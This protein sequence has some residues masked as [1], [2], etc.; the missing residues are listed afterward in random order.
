MQEERKIDFADLRSIININNAHSFQL[1]IDDIYQELTSHKKNTKGISK[2]TFIDFTHLPITIAEKLFQSLVHQNESHLDYNH[3][4]KFLKDLYI[5]EFKESARVI[6]NIY[7]F[8]KD[9]EININDVNHILKLLPI[10]EDNNINTMNHYIYQLESLNQ[11]VE[12]LNNFFG[13]T[14]SLNFESFLCNLETKNGDIF[15]QLICYLYITLPVTKES[16]WIYN[17]IYKKRCSDL[18]SNDDSSSSLISISSNIELNSTNLSICQNNKLSPLTDF[19]AINN[20]KSNNLR[21]SLKR[22]KSEMQLYKRTATPNMRLN[23]EFMFTKKKKSFNFD[24]S[25]ATKMYYI[26]RKPSELDES[27]DF[28]GPLSSREKT[29]NGMEVVNT[30]FVRKVSN[31]N[32]NKTVLQPTKS[33]ELSNLLK[34]S[35]EREK[36]GSIKKVISERDRNQRMNTERMNTISYKDKLSL[37]IRIINPLEIDSN[38]AED[39]DNYIKVNIDP[40]NHIKYEHKFDYSKTVIEEDNE[41]DEKTF[42]KTSI[43][44]ANLLKKNISNKSECLLTRNFSNEANSQMALFN[45]L[46]DLPSIASTFKDNFNKEEL[47]KLDNKFK[48]G[49]ESI[50]KFA[51]NEYKS[52]DLSLN[53][54]KFEETRKLVPKISPIKIFKNESESDYICTS[55]NNSKSSKIKHLNSNEIKNKNYNVDYYNISNIYS[56]GN[57]YRN[58]VKKPNTP[59]VYSKAYDADNNNSNNSNKKSLEDLN[60]NLIKNYEDKLLNQTKEEEKAFESKLIRKQGELLKLNNEAMSFKSFYVKLLHQNLYYYKEADEPEESYHKM[61]YING[62]FVKK[63]EPKNLKNRLYYCFSITF[64]NNNKTKKYYHKDEKEIKSWMEAINQA[65]NFKD[66]FMDYRLGDLLGKG[67]YGIVKIG[68]HKKT[69]KKMALKIINKIEIPTYDTMKTEIE[70][71]KLSKHPNIVQYIDYYENSEFIFIVMEYL[72]DGTLEEYLN[73]T[74]GKLTEQKAAK[75]I[76][77]IVSGLYYLKQFGIIHRDL[78][79]N[80]ILINFIDKDKTKRIVDREISVKIADFGFSKILGPKEMANEICGTIT[81]IAPEILRNMYYDYKVD[82]WSLGIIMYNIISRGDLPF[83][84]K[85]HDFNEMKKITLTKE[86][87]FDEK[88]NDK[89]NEVKEL[90]KKCLIKE[91]EKR[92]SIEEVMKDPWFRIIEKQS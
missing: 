83:Y 58:Q 27:V 46:S 42:S 61:H 82:V 20:T 35:P 92:I 34:K 12:H 63:Q 49:S 31:A 86:L 2:R 89:S 85:N 50:F 79:P 21:I 48:S 32:V 57:F 17:R 8:D 26:S 4:S 3:F 55:T 36:K 16:I 39:N 24:N 87:V 33:K 88:W 56:P 75:I 69:N 67:Q 44:S 84:S 5:G 7:D 73:K 6:F 81:Y 43:A 45:S 11:L 37:N 25:N 53:F 22:F 76:Y 78:K 14:E 15:L 19:F 54:K 91:S 38:Y 52:P 9:G 90:V 29:K 13:V 68:F 40:Y 59:N 60:N 70:V 41:E 23:P 18:T 51:S 28:T 65:N 74:K 66:F 72:T 71:L 77:D 64:S 80:N 47:D 1:Y 62:C 10:K 30:T